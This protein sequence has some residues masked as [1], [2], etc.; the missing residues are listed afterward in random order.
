MTAV[1]RRGGCGVYEVVVEVKVVLS[2]GIGGGGGKGKRK[3]REK[4]RRGEIHPF[5]FIHS[6][7]LSSILVIYVLR[8]I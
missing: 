7:T 6:R 8:R 4:E 5:I 2:V 1:D 3:R